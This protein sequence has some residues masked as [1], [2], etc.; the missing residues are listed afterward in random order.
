[1][2]LALQQNLLLGEAPDLVEVPDVVGQDQASATT[3]LETALFVVSVQN[4]YSSTVAAGNVISQ[5]PTAGTQRPEGSVVFIVISLGDEPVSTNKG[6]G[7]PKRRKRYLV[8][9]DGN[10]FEVS[11]PD[12]AASL[13]ERAKAVA[14]QKIEEARSERSSTRVGPGIGRPRIRSR[15]PELTQV[16][17]KAREEI[18]ALYD[19][20]VRDLEIRALMRKADEEEEEA[21]IR[22]LM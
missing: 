6:A 7:R 11:G 4:A 16:V 12:E 19:E 1:M 22:L 10:D 2:L 15:D 20:A 13:L 17:T 5:N 9:I 3:E 18:T 14:T 8:E 21:L